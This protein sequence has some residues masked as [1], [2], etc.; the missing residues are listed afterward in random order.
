M[1]IFLIMIAIFIYYELKLGIT[2]SS[3]GELFKLFLNLY[4]LLSI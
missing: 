1:T 2:V 4:E 3:A